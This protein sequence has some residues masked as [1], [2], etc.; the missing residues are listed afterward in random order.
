MSTGQVSPPDFWYDQAENE[1]VLVLRGHAK[2]EFEDAREIELLPGDHV[3][4][5]AHEKHRVVWTCPDEPTVWL[6]VFYRADEK[7]PVAL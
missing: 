5:P 6:A 1:W 2:L 3:L 4:I 7:S